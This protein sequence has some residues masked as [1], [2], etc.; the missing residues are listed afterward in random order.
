MKT[1]RHLLPF[2]PKLLPLLLMFKVV[3][4]VSVSVILYH[5][6]FKNLIEAPL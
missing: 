6:D 4:V 3:A 1:L 2:G 5:S